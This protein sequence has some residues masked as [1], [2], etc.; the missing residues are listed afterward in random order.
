[1]IK[2]YFLLEFS[3]DK[4]SG[5]NPNGIPRVKFLPNF[6]ETNKYG[7]VS[8][9]I[10]ESFFISNAKLFDIKFLDVLINNIENIIDGLK[11]SIIVYCETESLEV[12][13]E[14]TRPIDNLDIHGTNLTL[15]GSNSWNISTPKV[16]QYIP[17]TEI[18]QLFKDW[19][20][21]LEKQKSVSLI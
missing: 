11:E 12:T 3:W 6:E 2:Y 17:T 19:R 9:V 21:F 10:L 18:L 5:F 8:Y 14:F 15:Y 16:L 13:K 20:Q 7:Q 4:K 1:M